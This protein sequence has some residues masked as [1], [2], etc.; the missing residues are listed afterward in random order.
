LV[1]WNLRDFGQLV[2]EQVAWLRHSPCG[3]L[4]IRG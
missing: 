3:Q 4:G 2:G 1:G